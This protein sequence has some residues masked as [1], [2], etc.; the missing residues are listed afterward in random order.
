MPGGINLKHPLL[1]RGLMS[2]G[3]VVAEDVASRINTCTD[4]FANLNEML[5]DADLKVLYPKLPDTYTFYG[6][7][8]NPDI[9][10][11]KEHF[12]TI[13]QD[14]RLMVGYEQR[15]KAVEAYFDCLE[16]N[17]E[18]ENNIEKNWGDF[19]NA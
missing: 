1:T 10:A 9:A 2:L 6:I 14:V 11:A 12:K 17:S 19:Y 5:S 18:F 15:A 3:A 4:H 16:N 8:C 13:K 7:V